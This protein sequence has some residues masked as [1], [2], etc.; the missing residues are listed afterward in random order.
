MLG[1]CISSVARRVVLKGSAAAVVIHSASLPNE[2]V[3][4]CVRFQDERLALKVRGVNHPRAYESED[5]LHRN[6]VGAR[7]PACLGERGS[8]VGCH[9]ALSMRKHGDQAARRWS[10]AIH[11][12][13]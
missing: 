5:G 6:I 13:V 12:D 9:E 1:A 7:V 8:Y 3:L 4:N 10:A 11:D 2:D